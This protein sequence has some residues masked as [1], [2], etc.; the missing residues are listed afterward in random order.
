MIFIIM[1]SLRRWRCS[2]RIKTENNTNLLKY[3]ERYP[4]MNQRY[5]IQNTK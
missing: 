1:Y 5:K 3:E 2:E 4:N